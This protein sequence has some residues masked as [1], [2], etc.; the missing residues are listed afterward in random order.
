MEKTPPLLYK[1]VKILG[2]IEIT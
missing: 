1:K 2:L